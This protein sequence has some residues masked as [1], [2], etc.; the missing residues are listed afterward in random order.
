MGSVM[1]VCG[2]ISDEKLGYTL[3]HEHL[4]VSP[5]LP[6]KKY[7]EYRLE[8]I[9]LM[10][11]E[12]EKFRKK[13]GETIVEMTPINY[14]RDPS[15]YKHISVKENINIICCTGFHKEEFLPEWIFEEDESIIINLLLKEVNE[16]IENSKIFPGVIKCGTSY[17]NITKT[18][19]KVIK[20]VSKVH[21]LTKIPIST[22]C[23]KGTMIL[24]QGE[25]LVKCGVKPEHVL[26]GHTD[27]QTNIN[28]QLE[29]LKRGFNI[30]IDHVGRELMNTDEDRIRKLELMI[31]KGFMNQIFISGDMGKKEYIT[32][33]GGKPGLEYIFDSF[34]DK[35]NKEIGPKYFEIIMKNNPKR[36]FAF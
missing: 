14:G 27:V 10:Y 29:A 22:H 21:K 24:E 26:L 20:A 18:E 2:R 33:Y 17:N 7:D 19:E 12:V 16:G 5:N 36:F 35:F 4:I 23:D 3:P 13:Y 25:L 1:T 9:D 6:D 11:L 15:K 28:I 31:N 30:L 34:K 8:N 32:S